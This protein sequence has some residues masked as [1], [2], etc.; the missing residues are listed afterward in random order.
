LATLAVIS[1][2]L[3]VTCIHLQYNLHSNKIPVAYSIS[4]KNV[5]GKAPYSKNMSHWY[6][7]VGRKP[8][9]G[10]AGFMNDKAP[11]L[12]NMSHRYSGEGREPN[13]GVSG[14]VYDVLYDKADY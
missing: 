11:Y 5:S 4:F 13:P 8:D 6:S 2:Q 3:L 14:V 9:P 7:R 10:V 12:K 1:S